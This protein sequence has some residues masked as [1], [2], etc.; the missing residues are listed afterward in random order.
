M[1]YICVITAE[2]RYNMTF[3]KFDMTLIVGCI[4]VSSDIRFQLRDQNRNRNFMEV[5][6]ISHPNASK[7]YY[8]KTRWKLMIPFES[9]RFKNPLEAYDSVWKL[10]I[11]F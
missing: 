3:E 6:G 4:E 9:S 11:P 10:I 5:Y 7:I 8:L 1:I 2:K